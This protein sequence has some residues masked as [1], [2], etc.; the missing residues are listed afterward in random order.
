M[1]IYVPGVSNLYESGMDNLIQALLNRR[2]VIAGS[3]G[4]AACQVIAH[5]VPDLAVRVGAGTIQGDAGGVPVRVAVAQTDLNITANGTGNSRVDLVSVNFT[6][7]VPAVTNGTAAVTPKPPAMPAT[8]ILLGYV[9]VPPA[10]AN[11]QNANITDRRLFLP[12][13]EDV[14][15]LLVPVSLKYLD[16]GDKGAV[17]ITIDWTVSGSQRFRMTGNPSSLTFTAPPAGTWL[18][19]LVVQDGTGGRVLP[20]FPAAVKWQAGTAPTPTTTAGKKDL[21][22]FFYDGT[23]YIGQGALNY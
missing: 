15:A 4:G 2:A 14:T 22:T 12:A 11:I 7:G 8:D 6:T 3:G 5:A 1:P 17:A 9:S 10:A 13:S 19:L 21:Y 20:A 18:G 23:D 16:L